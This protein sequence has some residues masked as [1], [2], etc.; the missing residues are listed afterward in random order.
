MEWVNRTGRSAIWM[1]AR[2]AR[3]ERDTGAEERAEMVERHLLD[4]EAQDTG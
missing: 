1:H 3:G 4:A 2:S